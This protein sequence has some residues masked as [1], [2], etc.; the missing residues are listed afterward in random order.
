MRSNEFLSSKYIALFFQQDF[1]KN[2]IRWGKF[3]PN[4]ILLTNIGWGT[5]AHPELQIN[6]PTKSMDK[7]YFESGFLLNNLLAKKFFG[8]ARLGLG[9]GAFYRYGP[10][11]FSN[12][13][14]N[15]SLKVTWTYNFK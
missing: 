5:L 9:A 3:Q 6:S 11:A 15:L 2:I 10:Y 1:Q 7:G 14:D 12:P 13:I 4:L 8:V